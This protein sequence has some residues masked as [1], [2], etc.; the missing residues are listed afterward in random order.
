MYSRDQPHG[1]KLIQISAMLRLGC[2]RAGWQS[3]GPPS[4]YVALVNRGLSSRKACRV[5][6]APGPSNC[7]RAT[8]TTHSAN[9]L[10]GAGGSTL[11]TYDTKLEGVHKNPD[12]FPDMLS[13]FEQVVED[14][15]VCCKDNFLKLCGFVRGEGDISV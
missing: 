14:V 2:G 9:S 5:R 1:E 15:V 4:T 8:A 11:S 12:F 6:L 10:A 3:A 7:R 13:A